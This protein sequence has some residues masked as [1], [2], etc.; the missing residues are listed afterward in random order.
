MIYKVTAYQINQT[1]LRNHNFQML[2]N[3]NLIKAAEKTKMKIIAIKKMII[4]IKI[5][6]NDQIVYLFPDKISS[7]SVKIQLS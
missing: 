7:I 2:N 1:V 3:P 5:I 6:I 4:I